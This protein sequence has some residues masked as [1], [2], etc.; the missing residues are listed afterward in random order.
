MP[1]NFEK[2]WA[3]LKKGINFNKEY[4]SLYDCFN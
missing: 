3:V 4:V 2:T 1:Y